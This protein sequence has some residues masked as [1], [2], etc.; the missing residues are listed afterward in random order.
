MNR[1]IL[2]KGAVPSIFDQSQRTALKDPSKITKIAKRQQNRRKRIKRKPASE[3]CCSDDTTTNHVQ[4]VDFIEV[5]DPDFIDPKEQEFVEVVQIISESPLPPEPP[6]L[7]RTCGTQTLNCNKFFTIKQFCNDNEA[8]KFYTG[9]DSYEEFQMIFNTLCPN[10]ET[11]NN[12]CSEVLNLSTED[13]LFLTLIKLRRNTH[14]FELGILFEIHQTAVYTVFVMWINIMYSLWSK[15]KI[16]NNFND[17]MATTKH[18]AIKIEIPKEPSQSECIVTP[19]D[20]S[21]NKVIDNC[22]IKVKH[23]SDSPITDQRLTIQNTVS[24]KLI[25]ITIPA[26][27]VGKNK[28]ITATVASN[29]KPPKQITLKQLTGPTKTFCLLQQP[30]NIKYLELMTKICFVCQTLYNYIEGNVQRDTNNKSL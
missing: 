22:S 2:K 13:N 10:Y 3:S 27:F 7:T 6:I 17:K 9:L 5:K 11:I 15:K 18:I 16:H 4:E 19:P 8:I 14:D 21:K 1:K 24:P 26:L 30:I 23:A 20:E 29:E 25:P 28:P 12:K